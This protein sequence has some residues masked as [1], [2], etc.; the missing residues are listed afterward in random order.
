LPSPRPLAGWRALQFL[1]DWTLA[2]GSYSVFAKGLNCWHPDNKDW[3]HP[4]RNISKQV[5]FPRFLITFFFH[6][7]CWVVG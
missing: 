5:Y 6:Y 3:A 2:A 1:H 4:Q 7:L